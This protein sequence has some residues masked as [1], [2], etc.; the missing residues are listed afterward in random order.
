VLAAAVDPLCLGRRTHAVTAVLLPPFWLWR[1]GGGDGEIDALGGRKSRSLSST[2]MV[3]AV[4]SSIV[5][6]AAASSGVGA[7]AATAMS[8]WWREA[9]KVEGGALGRCI[10]RSRAARGFLPFPGVR[11]G[12]CFLARAPARFFE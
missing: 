1:L 2:S 5:E 7:P 4:T 3:E 11:R 6:T 10:E 12:P 9:E 8:A